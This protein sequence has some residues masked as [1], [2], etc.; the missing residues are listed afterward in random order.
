MIEI[1]YFSTLVLMLPIAGLAAFGALINSLTKF[2]LWAVI[3]VILAPLY[4]PFGRGLWILVFLLGFVGLCAAGLFPEARP[5]GLGAIITGG[6]ACSLY[7]FFSYPRPWEP[8]SFFFFVPST[9]GIGIGVYSLI[10][11]IA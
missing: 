1:L 7:V 6:A 10:R 4:D 3:K 8:G 11:P 2:G 9:L 5:Y